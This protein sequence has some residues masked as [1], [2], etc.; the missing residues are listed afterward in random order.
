[1]LLEQVGFEGPLSPGCGVLTAGDACALY[2]LFAAQGMLPE[3]GPVAPTE[4]GALLPRAHWRAGLV[5]AVGPHVERSE[6]AGVAG[7]G[8]EG[9][10]GPLL[11]AATCP[12]KRE[13][14]VRGF[15]FDAPPPTPPP[16]DAAG[17][18]FVA[19]LL[20][21]TGL[22][23]NWGSD[24]LQGVLL[25]WPPLSLSGLPGWVASARLAFPT[26]A[27]RGQSPGRR[28]TCHAVLS[29]VPDRPSRA[30]RPCLGRAE[31][32][33]GTALSSASQLC[34]SP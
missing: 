33:T 4:V 22:R 14:G 19:F 1:M 27:G 10:Q 31:W 13:C 23:L 15:G 24:S 34:S 29:P 28:L 3:P 9:G 5:G 2:S 26:A 20:V 25:T 30:P 32:P 18:E 6:G 7:T 16:Q 12:G 21:G 8:V 11:G 17:W